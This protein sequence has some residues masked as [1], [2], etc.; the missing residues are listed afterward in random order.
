MEARTYSCWA[1]VAHACTPSYSRGR[2]QKDRG[3]KTAW[4]NSSRD[5]ISKKPNT[6][7]AGG[8]APDVGPEFKLQYHKKKKRK[9]ILTSLTT[10][11]SAT[12]EY[13]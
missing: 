2:D 1:P 7:T 4:A 8:V 11:F 6:K 9:H 13:I 3:L 5:P 10:V 12:L